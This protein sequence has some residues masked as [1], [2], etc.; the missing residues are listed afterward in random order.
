[1]RLFQSSADRD[2]ELLSAY[3]DGA[4]RPSEAARLER[5]LRAEPELQH[6]LAEL[7]A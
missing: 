7:R 2:L 3:L 4:L 1:M 5:R 6:A